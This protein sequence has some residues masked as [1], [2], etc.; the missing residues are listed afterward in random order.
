M[1]CPQNRLVSTSISTT[2]LR[3]WRLPGKLKGSHWRASPPSDPLHS[4]Q[5]GIP[6]LTKSVVPSLPPTG[7]ML[8]EAQEGILP[9]QT[10]S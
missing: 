4:H 1:R 8:G 2:E 9:V 3:G 5:E 10:G 7:V 6:R